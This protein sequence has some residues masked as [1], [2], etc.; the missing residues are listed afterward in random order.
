LLAK[1]L[2]SAWDNKLGV[3]AE[4]NLTSANGPNSARSIAP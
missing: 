1:A 2:G 4:L 3:N